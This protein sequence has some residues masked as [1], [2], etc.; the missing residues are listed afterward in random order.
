MKKIANEFNE[1]LYTFK[2]RS[3]LTVKYLHRPGFKKNAAVL[4]VPFGALNIKQKL[5]GKEII[6]PLGVAHFLEHKVFEDE[7]EDILS[8]FSKLGGSANAFTSYQETMYYFTHD[9]HLFEPLALLLK[10]VRRFDIDKAS[11]EKEK[12]II[13]EEIKMYEQMPEMRLLAET[14]RNTFHQ[15][16]YIYDIAGTEESVNQTTLE[17]LQ[18]AYKLNYADEQMTLVL[19][20]DQAPQTVFDFIEAQTQ[21]RVSKG[22]ALENIYPQEP[23]TVVHAYR[24]QQDRTRST[25]MSLTYKFPYQKTNHLL[26]EMLLRF[27]LEMNFSDLN[28]DYQ[29]ALDAGIISDYF[30]YDVDLKEDF[31]VIYFFNESERSEQFKAYIEN[32]MN[33]LVIDEESF[34]QIKRKTYGDMIFSLSNP[35]RLAV[36]IARFDLQ[37]DD[38]FTYMKD[39]KNFQFYQVQAIL[40]LL[41]EKD[42]S[43]F[44]LK[45]KED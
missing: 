5:N 24:Q 36:N 25:K 13:V 8:Q 32:K 15:F 26:D 37:G 43:F 14:Y 18:M 38:Y 35:E 29:K 16:P 42:C 4:A 33:D 41:K 40:E 20:S 7:Q 27:V 34:M 39:V 9:T 10:F 1:N 21:T 22:I 11:V 17:N 3:N 19:V 45:Q 44:V 30:A 31:G 6:H 2:T 23:K 12:P 28:D